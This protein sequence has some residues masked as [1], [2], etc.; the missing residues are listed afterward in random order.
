M[1]PSAAASSAALFLA[2]ALC[3]CSEDEP[4]AP[5]DPAP[6]EDTTVVSYT[7]E[8]VDEY[9]HDPGAST[10]GLVWDDSVLIEG[11]GYYNGETSLRRVDLVSGAVLLKRSAPFKAGRPVFGEGVAR[12]DDRIVQLT[13]T[14]QVAWVYDAASFDSLGQF[15]YST[16]GWG[17]THD[18]TRFIMS[19]GTATLYFRDLAT[20]VET[21][22]VTVREAGNPVLL[23]NELE[24]IDGLVY[25]NI[26]ESNDIVLIDPATGRVRGRVDMTGILIAPPGVLNGIAWDAAGERLFVT[27]KLWPTLFE[28]RLVPVTPP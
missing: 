6:P 16:E 14:E 26:F 21:G 13:W 18:G 4:A 15:S 2:F 7:Y 25:A 23:L 17:L 8:I 10:Q 1:R 11:T 3:A 20:F 22:R 9:P 19:D 12:V 24:Y 5:G 28:I 27:G